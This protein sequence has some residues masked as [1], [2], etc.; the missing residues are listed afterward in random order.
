APSLMTAQEQCNNGPLCKMNSYSLWDYLPTEIKEYIFN[1]ADILTVFLNGQLS[2]D[3]IENQATEI[4]NYAF[5]HDGDGDLAKLPMEGLPTI[6]NGLCKARS[7]SIYHRLCS[8]RP[9]LR[10]DIDG[11][12]RDIIKVY[13]V[14]NAH[15]GFLK[16][17]KADPVVF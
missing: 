3:E 5:E 10:F 4:W 13:M 2:D 17:P 8:L 1:Y 15:Y 9:D 11:Q 6:K 14:H 7:R 12:L 16:C